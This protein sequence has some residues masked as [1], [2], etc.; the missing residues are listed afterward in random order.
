MLN[1]I[2][3]QDYDMPANLQL[4]IAKLKVHCK[5]TYGLFHLSNVIESTG[6]KEQTAKS[7]I[8]QLLS[9]GLIKQ[10]SF[11]SDPYK[12]RYYLIK[13]IGKYIQVDISQ[14]SHKN[15]ASFRAIIVEA[16]ISVYKGSQKKI[17]KSK[18]IKELG[19][20]CYNKNY[21][22]KLFIKGGNAG[23]KLEAQFEETKKYVANSLSAKIANKSVSTIQRYKKIQTV[24]EY[25]WKPVEFIPEIVNEMPNFNV[26][27]GK[28]LENTKTN[29]F[30]LSY[31][32]ERTSKLVVKVSSKRKKGL[33]KTN[34]IVK[35]SSFYIGQSLKLDYLTQV[36]F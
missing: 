34:Q 26:K 35:V 30:Y 18:L 36:P 14:F 22:K 13:Q 10:T 21:I 9:R 20:E 3:F 8:K 27:F 19:V 15:I 6:L 2:I 11:Q 7:H 16:K 25:S 33:V 12:R 24:S 1:R 31:P 23:I 32:C 4:T 29:S 17:I 5:S 28:I